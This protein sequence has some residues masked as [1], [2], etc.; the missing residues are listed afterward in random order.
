MNDTAAVL[1]A[2]VGTQR[3]LPRPVSVARVR[4]TLSRMG[5]D[6]VSLCD[7]AAMV[8]AVGTFLPQDRLS[9]PA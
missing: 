3:R 8:V 7:L 6:R 4:V 2:C 9:V 1:C 5:M